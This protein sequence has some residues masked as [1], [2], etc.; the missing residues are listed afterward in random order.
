MQIPGL[1][2]SDRGSVP[3]RVVALAACVL[4][5]SACSAR[6]APGTGAAGGAAGAP[7]PGALE[8]TLVE[9]SEALASFQGQ[10]KLAYD[11]PAGKLRSA[12]MVVVRSPHD[13]RIDFRSPFS[14]TY[15]VVCDGEQLIAYDRGEKVLYRGRP[16]SR[17]FGRYARVSVELH[18]LI[19]LAR[20]LP[21]IPRPA[22]AS[23]VHAVEGG[24]LWRIP[25]TTG[26]AVS[27]V[28]TRDSWLPTSARVD[29]RDDGNF[30]A[31]F[32]DYEDVMG[33]PVAHKIRAE[34][35]DGAIVELS[36]GTVWRDRTHGDNAFQLEP[37]PGVRVVDMDA[38]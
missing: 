37:P 18:M 12:N 25:S 27:I 7:T 29:G 6:R 36:Y 24:W 17:N 22:T 30:V 10:G 8:A 5:A 2:V 26:G 14:L 33:V 21:P 15:T 31:T 1:R 13:V 34:L 9:R 3:T 20:G 35:P 19:A 4:M 28:L 38:S 32:S 23:S 16:T 11:G